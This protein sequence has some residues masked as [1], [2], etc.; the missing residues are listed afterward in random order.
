M[1]ER[2]QRRRLRRSFLERLYDDVDGSVTE[3]VSGLDIGAGLEMDE[4]ETQ[5]IIGYL[6]EKGW[7]MVD[8][9]R[10]GIIRITA[11]GVDEVEA[12]DG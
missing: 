3:F 11:A 9:Y 2:N 12:R 10:A 7:I 1:T 4:V 6:E 8:D 5:R